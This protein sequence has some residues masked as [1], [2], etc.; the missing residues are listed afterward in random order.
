MIHRQIVI[1]T[2]CLLQMISRHSSYY[3]LWELFLDGAYN[4]CITNDILEEYEEI[5]CIKANRKIA[6]LVIEII[7]QAPNTYEYDASYKWEIIKADPDD[8]K[9]FDCAVVANADFIV[10]EDKHFNEVKN[11][12]FP[13]VDVIGLDEFSNLYRGNGS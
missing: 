12:S 13:H 6:S 8:N 5:L 2:N 11:N 3:F 10:T 7:R 9:F 1:D 4:L